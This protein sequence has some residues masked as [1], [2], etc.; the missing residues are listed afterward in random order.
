[1]VTTWLHQTLVACSVDTGHEEGRAGHMDDVR[2]DRR[3]I[4]AALDHGDPYAAVES[5]ICLSTAPPCA[6]ASSVKHDAEETRMRDLR[7]RRDWI[8]LAG[9]A[10]SVPRSQLNARPSIAAK[11]MHLDEL[12]NKVEADGH[13]E[14]KVQSSQ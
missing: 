14:G 9:S 5:E 11:D 10:L 12:G 3:G 13:W 4:S 1:M 8:C 2:S 6:S 7:A